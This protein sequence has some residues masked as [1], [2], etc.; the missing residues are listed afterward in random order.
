MRRSTT[1]SNG[2]P[3]RIAMLNDHGFQYGAGIAHLRVAGAL[4]L[5]GH[6]VSC[7]SLLSSHEKGFSDII[8]KVCAY[9]PDIVLFGNTHGV[10]RESVSVLERLSQ[11]FPC[12][13][14]THDFWLLTGRCAYPSDCDKFFTSGCDAACPSAA[15][16]PQIPLIH[17]EKAW[18]HKWAFLTKT[19]RLTVLAN[20]E[21]AAERYRR[22]C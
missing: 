22:I 16:Y 21:W 8:A 19:N 13:W 2:N 10:D 6:H 11:L 20:S 17:I 9:Q 5:A 3:L 1:P 15:E 4:D 12:Y 7:F 14:L 18:N